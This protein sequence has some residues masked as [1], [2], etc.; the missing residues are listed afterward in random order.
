MT[1]FKIDYKKKRPN[2]ESM[3]EEFTQVIQRMPQKVKH[4]A[5]SHNEEFDFKVMKDV[6]AIITSK[7]MEVE[8][9]DWKSSYSRYGME[10]TTDRF[11]NLDQILA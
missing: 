2:D 5:Y 4:V 6:Y 7:N 10:E 8:R 3:K 9:F 1:T 11:F